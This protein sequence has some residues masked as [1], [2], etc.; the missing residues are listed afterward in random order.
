[1]IERLIAARPNLLRYG[2]QPF[3]GIGEN[4]IDVEDHPP[5]RIDP[6]L[7]HLS[8]GEL[9]LAHRRLDQT[10][11]GDWVI[12]FHGGS[13]TPNGPAGNALDRRIGRQHAKIAGKAQQIRY[14]KSRPN[15]AASPP[16]SGRLTRAV[17]P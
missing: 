11:P 14:A 3:L 5:E 12:E 2:G 9:R 16:T 13:I 10:G 8:D 1:M 4:R 6:V 15:G 17:G 7:D